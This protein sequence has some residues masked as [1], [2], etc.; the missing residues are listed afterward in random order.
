MQPLTTIAPIPRTGYNSVVHRD[1]M[2]SADESRNK[3][4]E[5]VNRVNELT[6]LVAAQSAAISMLTERVD[7]L[8]P[9]PRKPAP[10]KGE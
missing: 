7:A 10:S 2:R 9:P 8:T 4:I 1:E 3:I 6:T 5:L